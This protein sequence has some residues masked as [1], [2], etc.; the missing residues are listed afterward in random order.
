MPLMPVPLNTPV[1]GIHACPSSLA[2]A[3]RSTNRGAF[4]G[5]IRT[6][7]ITRHGTR[8]GDAEQTSR[9]RWPQSETRRPRDHPP[10]HRELYAMNTSRRVTRRNALQLG[11]AATALPLVHIRSTGAAGKLTVGFWDHWVPA[12]ND[13]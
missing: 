10:P 5:P 11:A 6:S 1:T 8:A 13:V 7:S 2:S 12:T 9:H 4:P 3:S